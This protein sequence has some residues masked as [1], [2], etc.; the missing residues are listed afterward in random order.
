VKEGEHQPSEITPPHEQST[1]PERT[2]KM[3]R[4]RIPGERYFRDGDRVQHA[5]F[6]TG[7]VVTSKLTRSDEE[8]TIAFVGVGVK[9]LAA[10]LANLEI[11]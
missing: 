1:V 7:V 3:A 8:V 10:S 2:T 5:H 4:V 9:T 6:G 11:V